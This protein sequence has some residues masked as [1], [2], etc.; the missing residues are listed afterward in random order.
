M[1]LGEAWYS[2]PLSCPRA[3]YRPHP[4]A[5]SS[6]RVDMQN[7]VPSPAAISAAALSRSNAS[8]TGSYRN[9]CAVVAL[10]LSVTIPGRLPH[11]LS[12]AIFGPHSANRPDGKMKIECRQ[13]A[14]HRTGF[15]GAMPIARGNRCSF[16]L[17]STASPSPHLPSS[18]QPHAKAH[19]SIIGFK[20]SAKGSG[21]GL[22]S[23]KGLA[24]KC[25]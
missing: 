19:E 4:Q 25:G 8:S 21:Y 13:P 3:P 9:R 7:D 17:V 2:S 12:S 16:W 10:F 14:A 22:W 23:S 20:N 5:Y 24:E 18:S 15:Q 11:G 1:S 6:P